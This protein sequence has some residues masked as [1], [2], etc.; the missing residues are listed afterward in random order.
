[1]NEED[2]DSNP[3]SI[4]NYAKTKIESIIRRDRAAF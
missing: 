2:L 1:M 3:T 4:I